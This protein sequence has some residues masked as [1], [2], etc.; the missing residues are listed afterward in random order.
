MR[1]GDW[2]SAEVGYCHA[3]ID[4]QQVIDSGDDIAR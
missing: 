2:P 3:R 4:S 1:D